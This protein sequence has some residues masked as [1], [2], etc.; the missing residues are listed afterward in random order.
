MDYFT[1]N[2]LT[3]SRTAE[4]A[5]LDNTPGEQERLALAALVEKVLDPLREALGEPIRITSG[6]RSPEL[7]RLV[8]GVP[9]SQHL[10]GEAADCTAEAGP[11]RLLDLLYLHKIPFDQ[12]IVY[13][14]RNFLHISYRTDGKN[15]GQLIIDN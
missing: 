7:N 4:M 5:G 1:F 14:K 6:Y 10:K 2:E 11:E 9:T 15:R 8:G 3:Y 13:R 12:A